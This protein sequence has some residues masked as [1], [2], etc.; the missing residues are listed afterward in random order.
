MV[1]G[2]EMCMASALGCPQLERNV[3]GVAELEQKRFTDVLDVAVRDVEVVEVDRH[4]ADEHTAAAP[5][6]HA[7][8]ESHRALR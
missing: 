6:T 4:R 1:V 8:A 5:P 7:V 3:V 2:A